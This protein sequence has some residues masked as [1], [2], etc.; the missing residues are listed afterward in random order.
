MEEL[1]VK[2]LQYLLEAFKNS[3]ASLALLVVVI[4]QYRIQDKK[5]VLIQDLIEGQ[6]SDVERQA[7]M[8]V[9]LE[10]LVNRQSSTPTLGG[11][12]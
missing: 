9:L 5:D 8:L 3:P 6:R 1:I 10:I 4:L 2:M 12:R 7:R 11:G